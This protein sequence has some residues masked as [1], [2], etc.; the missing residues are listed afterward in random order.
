MHRTVVFRLFSVAGTLRSSIAV[1]ARR[2]RAGCQEDTMKRW[3][4]TGTVLAFGLAFA[5][6]A[7]VAE[8]K[9]PPDKL[10]YE[11]KRG[12]GHDGPPQ[13]PRGRQETLR[14]VSC[15]PG[16]VVC[17]QGPLSDVSHQESRVGQRGR[18]VRSADRE[19]GRRETARACIPTAAVERGSLRVGTG[20]SCTRNRCSP[21]AQTDHRLVGAPEIDE[22]HAKVVLGH[23]VVGN[24]VDRA[25]KERHT[26]VPVR[27]A[28]A[29]GQRERLS[30]PT[31]TRE[32][33]HKRQSSRRQ[34]RRQGRD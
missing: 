24:D 22:S 7:L 34:A 6:G 18:P 26:V 3:L 23:R 21:L 17:E 10:T 32:P 33:A 13:S 14:R 28:G 31:R 29:S 19:G 9:T 5:T 8:D 16:N 2:A 15:R 11:A 4:A 25:L 30:S 20:P 1:R 27:E 12:P